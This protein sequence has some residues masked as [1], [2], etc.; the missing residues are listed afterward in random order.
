[1][2]ESQRKRLEFRYAN[3]LCQQCGTQDERTLSGKRMCRECAAHAQKS[4]QYRTARRI[5]NH[6]CTACGAVDERTLSGKH[7]CERCA[8]LSSRQ[9]YHRL[10]KDKENVQ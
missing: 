2:R 1:M 10:K 6:E 9:Y 4:K 7:R 5:R 3:H 8:Q